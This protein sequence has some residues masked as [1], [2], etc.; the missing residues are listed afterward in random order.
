MH[1]V[2]LAAG[3]ATAVLDQLEAALKPYD[4]GQ[5]GRRIFGDAALRELLGPS[6]AMGRIASGSAG[7]AVQAV[8]AILFDK[9]ESVNWPLG[10]HQDRTIAVRSQVEVPGFESW[11]MKGGVPHVA[12]P[13]DL[14]KRLLTIRIHLDEVPTSNAPLLVSPGTH[15]LGAIKE[16]DIDACVSSHGVFTCTASRGDVWLYSTPILHASAKAV[17]PSRRRVLQVDFSPDTLPGRL[18][19]FGI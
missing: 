14:L 7:P 13:F 12:P 3:G 4:Q 18:Q 5:A 9:N 8:R 2:E 11:T 16:E 15:R 19:W 17:R 10:W 6:S 1:G